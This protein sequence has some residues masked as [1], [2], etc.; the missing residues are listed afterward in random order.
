MTSITDRQREEELHKHTR[1]TMS[2]QPPVVSFIILAYGINT[3]LVV[4]SAASE[5]FASQVT[6][7]YDWLCDSF[8]SQDRLHRDHLLM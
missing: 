5:M 4:L 2:N 3:T 7:F 1:P 8:I 6:I